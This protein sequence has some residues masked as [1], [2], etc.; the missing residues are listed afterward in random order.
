MTPSPAGE[1]V[2]ASCVALKGRALLIR[3]ASGTGKSTLALGLMAHGAD[4]VGDDRV[5]LRVGPQGL[6]A[7]AVPTIEGL[8]EARGIGILRATPAGEVPVVAVVD[9]DE[10][11]SERVPPRRHT[12]LLD[13]NVVLLRRVEGPHFELGLLQFMKAGRQSP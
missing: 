3:G 2:H 8:I 9:L 1:I 11:E 13:Q 10:I 6:T 12:C 4:L 5:L 7:R